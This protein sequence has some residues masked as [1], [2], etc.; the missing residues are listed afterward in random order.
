MLEKIVS[1]TLPIATNEEKSQSQQQ[2]QQ[3][4]SISSS[5]NTKPKVCSIK[6][7]MDPMIGLREKEEGCLRELKSRIKGNQ[8]KE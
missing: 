1:M 7:T 6:V 2:S 3:Q 8:T 4:D 5:N